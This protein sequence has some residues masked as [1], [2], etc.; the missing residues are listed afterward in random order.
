MMFAE[1]IHTHQP[2]P[3]ATRHYDRNSK[4]NV[5]KLQDFLFIQNAVFTL[6]RI[7]AINFLYGFKM[8]VLLYRL[9]SLDI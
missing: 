2:S 8:Q 9:S 1:N 6:K 5:K 4:K 3:A 7:V